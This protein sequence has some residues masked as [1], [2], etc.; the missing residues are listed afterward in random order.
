MSYISRNFHLFHVS[1]VFA[2]NFRMFMLLY[3]ESVSLSVGV[4]T[5]L[6]TED[7]NGRELRGDRLTEPIW[8]RAASIA[9][10]ARRH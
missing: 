3:P 10:A 4:I 6:G 8:R 9:A 7:K 1:N 5:K 2:L